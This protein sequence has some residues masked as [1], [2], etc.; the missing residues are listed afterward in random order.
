MCKRFTARGFAKS[1]PG[2]FTPAIVQAKLQAKEQET[3]QLQK[4]VQDMQAQL[5]SFQMSGASPLY[6]QQLEQV[7]SRCQALQAENNEIR[8]LAMLYMDENARLHA[9][10]AHCCLQALAVSIV[11]AEIGVDSLRSA[12]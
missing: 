6:K 1:S 9:V 11:A 5:L 12:R 7:Q 10:S 4:Q 3:L 8:T 2:G